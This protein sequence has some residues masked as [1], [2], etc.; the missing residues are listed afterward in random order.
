ML[1]GL[2][3]IER[4]GDRG[5]RRLVIA[6]G[7]RVNPPFGID[8]SGG[9][10]RDHAAVLVERAVADHR[11]PRRRRPL[12]GIER[13]AIV[14]SV[15][16][17]GARRA[18]RRDLAVHGRRRARDFQQPR[19]DAAL[20]EQRARPRRRSCECPR[21][22]APGWAGRAVPGTRREWRARG[23]RASARGLAL[24][25]C[26]RLVCALLPARQGPTARSPAGASFHLRQDLAQNLHRLID[27]LFRNDVRRQEAQHRIVRA[28][29]EQPSAIASSTI[30]LPG[31]CSSTPSIRPKPR[32]SLMNACLRAS[33]FS[34]T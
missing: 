26:R 3:G 29:D 22:R 5:Q 18:R 25:C 4:G 34:S 20:F 17:H 1:R 15:E 28:V 16:D 30:C 31:M 33:S 24:G 13:L 21:Y 9:G 11:L 32:T 27:F 10:Q 8:L 23:S 7:A 2:E 14:V 12:L 19:L 6:G